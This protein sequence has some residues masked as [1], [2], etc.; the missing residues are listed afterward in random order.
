MGEWTKSRQMPTGRVEITIVAMFKT[1]ISL[2][3]IST[4]FSFNPSLSKSIIEHAVNVNEPQRFLPQPWPPI[5]VRHPNGLKRA[6]LLKMKCNV[7]ARFGLH[8]TSRA[9]IQARIAKD[10]PSINPRDQASN[11]SIYPATVSLF[12]SGEVNWG[13]QIPTNDQ[14]Q[15]L[16]LSTDAGDGKIDYVTQIVTLAIAKELEESA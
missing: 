1:L 4:D 3:I 9:D 15:E 13:F 8:A 12:E 6:A 10:F 7:S 14:F 2:R 11:N 16:D 5:D